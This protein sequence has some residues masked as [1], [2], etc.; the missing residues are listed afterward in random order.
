MS[1]GPQGAPLDPQEVLTTFNP[2]YD[3]WCFRR[4]LTTSSFVRYPS[5]GTELVW[6]VRSWFPPEESRREWVLQS[7]VRSSQTSRSI[8]GYKIAFSYPFNSQRKVHK[9][10]IS[11]IGFWLTVTRSFW[12]EKRPGYTLP[13]ISTYPLSDTKWCSFLED[14]T[15][16]C[17]LLPR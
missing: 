7:Q 14:E 2:L 16:T 11:W 12:N 3:S 13:F 8:E 5:R 15:L 9:L 10:N 6:S 4:C 17:P 1:R